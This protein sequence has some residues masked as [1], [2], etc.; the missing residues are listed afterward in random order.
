MS[1]LRVGVLGVGEMGMRHAEN[2]RHRVPNAQLTAVAD[3]AI[4]RARRVAYDLEIENAHGSLEDMLEDV[5]LDAVVVA[6]PDS[7]HAKAVKLAAAAGKAILRE[8]PRAW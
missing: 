7:S 5:G 2:L 8:K 6:T 3:V 4:E 1:R